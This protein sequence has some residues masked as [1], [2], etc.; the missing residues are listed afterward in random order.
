[1]LILFGNK[2]KE[3][4][5]KIY[6][7][8][9][10]MHSGIMNVILLYSGQTVHCSY[11]TIAHHSGSQSTT[12]TCYVRHSTQPRS[13]QQFLTSNILYSSMIYHLTEC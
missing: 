2:R 10:D 1:M 3:I 13:R 8:D 11:Y 12:Y 6:Y 5:Y 7:K 4:L 9:Q